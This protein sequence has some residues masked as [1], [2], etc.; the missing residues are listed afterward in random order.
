M[1]RELIEYLNAKIQNLLIMD[2]DLSNDPVDTRRRFNVDT[3]PYD[4]VRLR[5]DVETTLCVFRGVNLII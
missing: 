1:K 2:T 3:T 4:I 5:I